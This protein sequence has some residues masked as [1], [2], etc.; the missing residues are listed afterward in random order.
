MPAY[1]PSQSDGPSQSARYPQD[2]LDRELSDVNRGAKSDIVFSIAVV[3]LDKTAD[4]TCAT[5]SLS[6][7]RGAPEQ[8]ASE[9]I[10]ALLQGR[11]LPRLFAVGACPP[12]RASLELRENNSLYEE[13]SLQQVRPLSSPIGFCHDHVCPYI[14][15][16]GRELL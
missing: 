15:D 2:R 13:A 1:G 9:S 4:K 11:G 5:P 14:P 12:W 7:H 10:V 16:V 8:V 3:A 6:E